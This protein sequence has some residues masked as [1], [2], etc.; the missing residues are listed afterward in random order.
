MDFVRAKLIGPAGGE[1][2]ILQKGDAPADK[3]ISGILFP[4]NPIPNPEELDVDNDDELEG[5][6]GLVVLTQ[7]FSPSSAGLSFLTTENLAL[8]VKV[9]AACYE[10]TTEKTWT[11]NP[12]GA[13]DQNGFVVELPVGAKRANVAPGLSIVARWRDF[14]G[15]K[16]VTVSIVNDRVESKGGLARSQQAFFQVGMEVEPLSGEIRP[17]PKRISK[18][19]SQQ[20]QVLDLNFKDQKTYAVGHG[21]SASWR[22]EESKVVS[23]CIDFMPMH[24]V[25]RMAATVPQIRSKLSIK[26]LAD[27]FKKPEELGALD[28]LASAYRG[29]YESL[30]EASKVFIGVELEAANSALSAIRNCAAR[31][32]VGIEALRS[33][34]KALLAF[35]L[36]NQA[37]LLQMR[38][39]MPDMAGTVHQVG[40]VVE[41]IIFEE[42]ERSWFPFQI[43]F[44]L[45][46]LKGVVDPDSIDRNV[47]DVLWFPT[48]GGKTEAYLMLLAFTVFYRRLK[49]PDSGG[50]TVAITRYTLRLLTAQQFR[51]SSTL[52]CAMEYLRRTGTH[53]G[54]KLRDILGHEE[55]SIGLWVGRDATPNDF[56]S[57][58]KVINSP[59]EEGPSM[60]LPSCP[61]CGTATRS[62]SGSSSWVIDDNS[63]SIT[64]KCLNSA[65][66]FSD[67]LPVVTV[68]SELYKNPPTFLLATVDKFAQF[69]WSD[70]PAAF[71]GSQKND[72]P[73]LIIQDELHLI[74]G[75]LGTL[76]GAYEAAFD[77]L[78]SRRKS[79][80]IVAS[81]ATVRNPEEQTFALFG[82]PAAVFPPPGLDKRDSFFARED[83]TL[84]RKYVG[85]MPQG[86]TAVTAMARLSASLLQ[87]PLEIDFTSPADDAYYTVVAYHNSLRE[88]S[89][90]I[91]LTGDDIPFWASTYSS[92]SENVR[93]LDGSNVQ[94]LTSNLR[95]AEIQ[96]VFKRLEAKRGDPDSLSFVASTN[97]FSVGV[98]VQRLGLMLVSGQPKSLAEYIQATS[99]VGRSPDAPGLVFSL[100]SP[101]RSRDRSNFETFHTLHSSLYKFV[102][103]QTL[104]PFA[105]EARRRVLHACLV[106]LARHY[107]GWAKDSDASNFDSDDQLWIQAM[108]KF[109]DRIALSDP[110]ELEAA[111]SEIGDFEAL[112]VSLIRANGGYLSYESQ[113]RGSGGLL[114]MFGKPGLGKPTMNQMRNTDFET[115]ISVWKGFK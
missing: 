106:I 48:G 100:F 30:E 27:S 92:T 51:R 8:L 11:R 78:L 61:W 32:E 22:E 55:F 9:S 4:R 38:H 114:K 105:P 16:F 109:R 97:M 76:V 14:E 31:I 41:E 103:Y 65:C 81:S 7:K 84:T 72:P 24:D 112:W 40:E 71:L 3:Y 96:S 110:E 113:S 107:V 28:E 58:K 101:M 59:S 56:A 18:N 87:A 74:T 108:S 21:C 43:A 13:S 89:K 35:S 95:Q 98:D 46:A 66:P 17:Y 44:A 102:E 57:A 60:A 52:L 49:N 68:D 47:V 15:A 99:R 42:D 54:D 75:P 12:V 36:A 63:K 82:R 45:L 5:E 26:R 6:T 85:V 33:D 1:F 104:T 23:V 111:I 62:E 115:K 70:Q 77:V 94:E 50:G 67:H 90:T 37:M 64:Q 19:T 88:L 83:L 80:K 86:N 20:E 2:E 39:S 25:P 91:G 53:S 79:P 93:Q 34:K 69:V 73:E 29:W 10:L